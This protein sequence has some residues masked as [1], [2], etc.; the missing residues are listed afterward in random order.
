MSKK[1]KP[2]I[3]LFNVPIIETHCHLDYLKAD[4][5]DTVIARSQE[6]GIEKIITIA[7]SPDNLPKVRALTQ[8]HSMIFGSQGIHPHDAKHCE[9]ETLN[10][11]KQHSHDDKIVAIGEIGLD[12]YYQHS[13][14][15]KQKQVFEQHLQIAVD[16]NKPIIVHTRDADEDT[17][18]ILKNFST[19]LKR[20]GVI[21][22]FSSGLALAEFCLQEGFSLGFNGMVTF[23]NADNVRAAVSLCPIEQ[24]LLETDSPYLTPV[25]YRGRE[26]APYYLPFIAEKIAEVKNIEI[27]MLLKHCYKNSVGLFF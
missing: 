23:K 26:N 11:I 17:Q 20:K 22:S 16:E 4:E 1:N 8:T 18:A 12:Y 6:T 14:R 27:E 21:H 24:L 25:P 10:E 2:D 9:T 13:D 5:L 7:V 3:P 19:H 15:E